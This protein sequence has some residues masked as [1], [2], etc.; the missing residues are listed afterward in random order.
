MDAALLTEDTN[1]SS[2][3]NTVVSVK[4][5]GYAGISAENTENQI[6]SAISVSCIT[7]RKAKMKDSGT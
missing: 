3:H 1:H 7:V 6:R 5:S 2:D 4:S